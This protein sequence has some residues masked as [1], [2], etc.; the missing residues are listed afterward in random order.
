MPMCETTA[1]GL[2]K[3]SQKHLLAPGHTACAGCGQAMAAMLVVDAAGPN[4]IITNNTGCLEVFTTKAPETAWEVPW[5]HSLFENAAAV[6][7]GIEAALKYLGIAEGINV[8]AQ[9]GDGGTADIGLQ[10]LS[11]MFDRRHNVLYVCYDNEAYMNTGVQRSGLTPFD[12]ST[13]TSPSGKY[14]F[15]NPLPKKNMVEIA[16]AHGIPYAASASVA[17]PRDIQTKVKKAL[18][19][20]GP[21]YLQIHV[22]CP[23]GWRH[24]PSQ[25]M[26]VARL[27]VETGLYPLIEFENG[28]FTKARQMGEIKPVTE[29]L[30]T[31][32]RFRHLLTPEAEEQVKLIQAIADENVRRYK[33]KREEKKKA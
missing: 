7:S 5:I 22:P 18:S 14:S 17:F 8:I 26:I 31:Q 27:A 11:G 33:L 23:L 2:K 3:P 16:A 6:A 10:A 28:V 13:T 9:G 21:K 30:K 12:S 24:D 4:T 29:Y 25:T 32:A 1:T 19:L 15:G 20:K